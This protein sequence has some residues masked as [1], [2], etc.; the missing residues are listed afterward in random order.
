MA[1]KQPL[2]GSV[3]KTYEIINNFNSEIDII[4]EIKAICAEDILV[5]SSWFIPPFTA[6]GILNSLSV[7]TRG[8][9]A[10]VPLNNL[11]KILLAF[12]FVFVLLDLISNRFG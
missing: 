11:L 6:T 5:I 8:S 9:K 7:I 4:I 12:F 3:T 10:N 1:T 2:K